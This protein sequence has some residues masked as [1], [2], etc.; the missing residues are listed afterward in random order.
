MPHKA[1][2]LL[3]ITNSFGIAE[4]LNSYFTSIGPS[5][6]AKLSYEPF[7][8]EITSK[9]K[10]D[11]SFQLSEVDESVI[12]NELAKLNVNKAAGP[13]EIPAKFIKLC[14]QYILK[15]F[16][17]VVN[18]SLKYSKVPTEM[19]KARIRAL[20]KN[21]WSKMLPNNYRP[22]SVLPIFSKILEKIVNF[23][24]QSF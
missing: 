4:A 23:Q 15:P 1:T 24:L 17:H 13:D 7:E 9:T 19:K 16:T 12:Y 10:P 20:Y 18:L 5:L 3:P 11:S 6:A 21:K 8:S 2:S 14:G 22:I